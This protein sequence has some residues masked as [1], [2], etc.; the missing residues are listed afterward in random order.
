MDKNEEQVRKRKT[1]RRKG[2]RE[3]KLMD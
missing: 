1:R 3:G 2:E